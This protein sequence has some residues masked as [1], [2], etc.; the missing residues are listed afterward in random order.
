MLIKNI[1]F[2]SIFRILILLIKHTNTSSTSCNSKCIN[3]DKTNN[4]CLDDESTKQ[5]KNLNNFQNSKNLICNIKNCITCGNRNECLKCDDGYELDKHRCYNTNCKVYGFCKFCDE[6]DCLKCIKGYQLNYGMCEVKVNRLRTI[7]IFTIISP[8]IILFVII[9]SYKHY[10]N[11][12][13]I[14]IKTGKVIK[15]K[16]PKPGN[17]IVNIPNK[18]KDD[19]NLHDTSQN[20]IIR[21]Y[22]DSTFQPNEK[23]KTVVN[24][25][26]V[27]QKKKI[28]S[29][30]DCGCSLC[31]EHWN[32]INN[33]KEKIKCKIH[34]TFLLANITFKL[35]KKSIYKGNAVE[36]LGLSLCPI[37]KIQY[38][39]QSFNCG[40]PMK[41]CEK[42]FNDNVYLLKYNHCPGCGKPYNPKVKKSKKIILDYSN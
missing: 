1:I 39:T 34:K 41:I 30:A 38:A 28:Y 26:V 7:I 22:L 21:T 4:I 23:D 2:F 8:L 24:C 15:F 16:H 40:C 3:C 33:K 12:I 29:I 37:C 25:C 42:C 32:L 18:L 36:K 11:I 31:F 5:T 27:C 35:E 14:N 20:I 10:S 13:N 19:N 6:Y 17:Y 9:Y